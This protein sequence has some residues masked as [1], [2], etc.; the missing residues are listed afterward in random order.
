[1]SEYQYYEF[2]VVDRHLTSAEIAKL[3]EL[4]SRAN[5]TATGFAVEYNYGDFRGKPELLMERYFDAFVYVANWGNHQLMLRLPQRGLDLKELNAFQNDA[6]KVKT[7]SDFVI[8]DFE[9]DCEGDSSY[10]EGEVYMPELIPL[11]EELLNGDLRPLYLGWLSGFQFDPDYDL[12]DVEKL[13]P[14]VPPGLNSLTDAQTALVDFLR[15]DPIL[16]EAAALQSPELPAV[17]SRQLQ[18]SIWFKDIPQKQKDDWLLQLVERSDPSVRS[19]IL[20]AFRESQAKAM[21]KSASSSPKRRTFQQLFEA[22]EA[23]VEAYENRL[24]QEAAAEKARNARSAAQKR[25]QELDKLA[26]RVEAAWNELETHLK[27]T[28]QN[29]FIKVVQGLV[30]L[31]ELAQ[32]DGTLESY[33]L[34]LERFMKRHADKLTLQKRISHANLTQ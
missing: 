28:S 30:D 29:R 6:L 24:A 7:K 33:R 2:R 21:P 12:S 22:R 32:R 13:E 26:G 34:K 25:N 27:S 31:R 14:P 15:I 11:R 19:E 17:E 16:V 18:L 9:T 8:F 10:E 20:A 1:M 23:H 5:V 3:N 4:S